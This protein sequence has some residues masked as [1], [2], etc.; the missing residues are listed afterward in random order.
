MRVMPSFCTINPELHQR[1]HGLRGGIDDVEKALMSAHLEL[2]AALLVDMRRP[3]HGELLNLSRQRHGA[4]DAGTGT[5]GRVHDLA[6]RGIENSMI[7]RFEPDPDILTVHRFVSS[8]NVGAPL[9][10]APSGSS[11]T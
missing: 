1:V 9:V 5:L 8:R 11:L 10:R 6:R 3:V 2:L 4:D 7:E